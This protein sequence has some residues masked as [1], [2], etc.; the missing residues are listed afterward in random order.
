MLAVSVMNME[1]SE[2]VFRERFPECISAREND[3]V[4]KIQ[5]CRYWSLMQRLRRVVDCQ[6]FW[7]VHE[8]KVSI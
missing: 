3:I 5:L 8:H 4:R 6:A 2:K 7:L 1:R